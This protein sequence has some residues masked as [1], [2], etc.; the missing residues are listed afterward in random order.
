MF[1]IKIYRKQKCIILK[2][3]LRGVFQ[4]LQIVEAISFHK[5]NVII[6]NFTS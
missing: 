4:V 1:H 3:I 5:R 6:V 2:E